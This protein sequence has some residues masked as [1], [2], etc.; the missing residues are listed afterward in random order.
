M[1]HCV[2]GDTENLERKTLVWLLLINGSMFLLELVAG[3]V[4]ESTGLLADSL[5]MLADASVYAISLYAVGRA[6]SVQV[7][8]ARV[9]G[10]IQICLGIGVLVDV[11][12]RFVL[13]SEPW[14]LVMMACGTLALIAN[15]GCLALLAKHRQGGVHMRASW[16]FSTNDVIANLGVILSGL[17]VFLFQSRLPDLAVGAVVST[18]VVMGGARIL[19]EAKR[20]TS[21]DAE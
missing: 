15:V 4:A 11:L 19:R 14:S 17:L 10:W 8:A 2:C 5:D 13:G 6:A 20:E 12:R 1:N 16:I 9:S 3:W 7:G 21:A 18:L